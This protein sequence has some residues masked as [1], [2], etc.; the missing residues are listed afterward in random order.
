MKIF[1]SDLWSFLGVLPT[2]FKVQSHCFQCRSK[3]FCFSS[4]IKCSPTFRCSHLKCRE[5]NDDKFYQS[6]PILLNTYSKLFRLWLW[7]YLLVTMQW[8]LDEN[9][10]RVVEF[11]LLCE[12]KN[13]FRSHK[14]IQQHHF[15][16]H[17]AN[18]YQLFD[19]ISLILFKVVSYAF[20]ER[21]HAK[22]SWKVVMLQKRIVDTLHKKGKPEEFLRH[23][24]DL[25][26]INFG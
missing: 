22:R 7:V 23:S 11:F 6:G 8:L 5:N 13:F 26:Y 12:R 24:L 14:N 3:Y 16:L 1:K 17:L 10:I 15:E 18:M 2:S 4:C 20:L 25:F 9:Q 19:F 21:K